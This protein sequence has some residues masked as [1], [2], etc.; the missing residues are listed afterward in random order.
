[1]TMPDMRE[2]ETPAPPEAASARRWFWMA[3]TVGVTVLI[4]FGVLDL[5]HVIAPPRQ[6]R[7]QVVI[8]AQ[9]PAQG[10]AN[11]PTALVVAPATLT[12]A[13]HA[14]APVTLTNTTARPL[15]WSVDALPADILVDSAS[16]RS[17]ILA[18]GES[19]S[20]TLQSLGS[21]ADGQVLFGDDLGEQVALP[22]RA[23]CP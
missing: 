20:L 1:M 3:V 22:V 4:V 17:G 19:A 12:L 14:A 16:P 15:R 9:F 13:C 7:T 2:T 6:P 5:V 10:N 8:N 23:Q 21:G 11:G 18:A